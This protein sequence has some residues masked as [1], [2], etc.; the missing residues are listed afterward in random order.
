[1]NTLRLLA[2]SAPLILS[3]CAL[4]S[5]VP[6]PSARPAEPASLAGTAWQLAEIQS[7]NDAQGTI[8]PAPDRLYSIRFAA[9]G[10]AA[11]QLDCNRGSARWTATP[12]AGSAGGTLQFSTVA[13][14]RAMCAPPVLDTRIARDLESVRSY[15]MRDGTLSMSLMADG[16]I[17]RWTP[18]AGAAPAP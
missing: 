8:R 7:M 9:D 12:A 5:Q 6:A 17:Y 1:M 16:G 3:A 18:M 15:S 14:T 2:V 11:F 13:L 4:T 10:S